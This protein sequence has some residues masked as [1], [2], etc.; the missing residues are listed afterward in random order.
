MK[1]SEFQVG[2]IVSGLLPDETVEIIQVV[3][4]GEANASLVVKKHNGQFQELIVTDELSFQLA[5]SVSFQFD[6]DPAQF[7]LAMEAKRMELA[8]IFDPFAALSSSNL[9]P[10]P[11]QLSAVYGELLNRIPLR[12]LLADEPGAGKTIMAGLLIKE[13]ILRGSLKRCLIVCPGSLGEQWSDELKEK[14]G[15]S[16]RQLTKNSLDESHHVNPFLESNFIIA[17]MDQLA[18]SSESV[19]NRIQETE[20]D[21][22]IIDEA[23]RM[24]AQQVGFKNEATKTLRFRLGQLLS[25]QTTH[26]L[27]MTATPHTGSDENFHLFLSLLDN[28]MFV[29]NL[30]HGELKADFSPV[31]LRRV[32]E[33]LVTFEGKPLFPPR[34][35]ITVSYKLSK[36]ELDLY[37][38]VTAYVKEEMARAMA[39]YGNDKKKQGNVSFALTVLQ[40]RLASSP[41]AIRNSLQRRLERILA[42]KEGANVPSLQ[43]EDL[44]E[45]IDESEDF[46]GEMSEEEREVLENSETVNGATAA[47]NGQELSEEV[48]KLKSLLASADKVLAEESDSK[49]TELKSIL[50]SEDLSGG[51]DSSHEKLIIFT[52]HRDTLNYL[53]SRISATLGTQYKVVTIHGGHSR[54]ERKR[55]QAEFTN[56]PMAPILVATDAAG[57]GINLQRAHFMVNYDL[58]WNPNRIEQRFGRIHRIGQLSECTLWNLVSANTREGSVYLRLLQKIVTQGDAYNGNLF[59]ILGGEQLFEGKSLAALLTE[60]I[61]GSPLDVEAELDLGIIKANKQAHQEAALMPEIAASFDASEIAKKM[62]EAKLKR[63]APGFVAGF[64]AAAFKDFGGLL[65]E[66]EPERYKIFNVPASLA[67]LS[68]SDKFIGELSS[69]YERVTFKAENVELNGA[70]NAELIALGSP[71]MN[72][73]VRG[74]LQKYANLL[75]RGTFFIDKDP[76]G[77]DEVRLLVCLSQDIVNNFDQTKPIE[78]IVTFIEILLSG[79]TFFRDIPPVF[80]FV[81]PTADVQKEMLQSIIPKIDVDQLI[82]VGKSSLSKRTTT[83]RLPELKG[84]V[85]AQLDTTRKEVIKRMDQEIKFWENEALAIAQGTRSNAK[86]TPATAKLKAND[87][88][89]RKALRLDQLGREGTILIKPSKVVSVALVVPAMSAPGAESLKAVLY[90]KD[91]E[92]IKKIERRA[93]DL[94]LSV[95]KALGFSPKEMP[96][97]NKGFDIDSFR[98][99]TGRTFIE[100]KGRIDGAD[101]FII[102][103]SEFFLG[104]TQGSSFILALVKVASGEDPTKDQVRYIFDPFKGQLPIWGADAHVLSMKKYWDTGFDPTAALPG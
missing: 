44:S 24:S 65:Q 40:R 86:H 26:M 3:F 50:E 103:N 101:N 102:T 16:F 38:Q 20:W 11:H 37:N 14:F 34:K 29:G 99:N 77:P 69:Q 22:V 79:E 100:V 42:T 75:D 54:E 78:R 92:A 58:P 67:K 96:R 9:Q 36:S 18:R 66:K 25:R 57:E 47:S 91:Q 51:E 68:R 59:H 31:M 85:D 23:H 73:V 45:S 7:K 83:L 70:P 71:L 8:G 55:S 30:R 93:V 64:F 62:N 13:L 89:A 33:N 52:E 53:Q 10:L 82:E 2:Q 97:N 63:L 1:T 94:V 104:H 27:L 61:I 15:L 41:L 98:E 35:A 48:E 88:R 17:R 49:W 4:I 72:V 43:P 21:L 80:D 87:H 46:L 12:F 6:A 28:D 90:P 76:E 19:K 5:D 60:A 84:L 32:K 74:V 39:V 95:E 56:N 81:L